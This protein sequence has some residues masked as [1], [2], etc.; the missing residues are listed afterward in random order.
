MV[1]L[2]L[3]S[4]QREEDSSSNGER[5]A[6]ARDQHG[7]ILPNALRSDPPFIARRGSGAG[8]GG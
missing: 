3:T 5:A 4:E 2:E 7:L 1:S 8:Y 6:S